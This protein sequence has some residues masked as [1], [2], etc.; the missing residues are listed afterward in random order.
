[1]AKLVVK[2]PKKQNY[3]VLAVLIGVLVY[4]LFLR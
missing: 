2:E 3:L 1:M 4:L